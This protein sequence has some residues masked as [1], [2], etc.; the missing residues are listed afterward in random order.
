MDMVEKEF[1]LFSSLSSGPRLEILH[2][3]K[4]SELKSSQIAKNIQ[5]SIQAITRHLAKLVESKL[6]EKTVTGKYRLTPIADILMLQIP[7]FEFLENHKEFFSTHDFSGIPPHLIS[8]LGD[9]V[10]CQLETDLMKSMQ[11]SRDLCANAK[12]SLISATF[13]VPLEY[14][15]TILENLE[16]GGYSK[17]IYGKNTIVPKGFS[18]YLPRKKY[19]EF[20]KNGQLEEKIVEHIPIVVSASD[21]ECQILFANKELGIP[22]CQSVFFSKDPKFMQW[23]RDLV[24]YYWNMPAIENYAL[25]EQ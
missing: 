11:H 16:Q 17:I 5:S 25:K 23:C 21:N 19:L 24:D 9:L 22:D 2:M 4:S 1:D 12:K 13:T 18:E 8:R 6:I 15:D 7:L 14:Y 3:L 20:L 10:N